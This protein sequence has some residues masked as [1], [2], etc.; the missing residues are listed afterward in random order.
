MPHATLIIVSAVRSLLRP[1]VTSTSVQ[2]STENRSRHC[3]TLT[4]MT[5]SSAHT[6]HSTANSTVS[7]RPIPSS[8]ARVMTTST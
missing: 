1:M 4:H 3:T 7:A 8:F 5:R 6:S 2:R